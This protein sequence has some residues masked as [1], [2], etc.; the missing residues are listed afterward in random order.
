MLKSSSLS[1][2]ESELKTALIAAIIS[3]FAELELVSTLLLL[4]LIEVL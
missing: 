1:V 4:L 3:G 2:S